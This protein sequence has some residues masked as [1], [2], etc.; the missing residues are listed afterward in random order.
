MLDVGCWMFDV[1]CLM[2]DVGYHSVITKTHPDI[3]ISGMHQ[4]NLLVLRTT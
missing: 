1:G 4:I 2:L 3:L